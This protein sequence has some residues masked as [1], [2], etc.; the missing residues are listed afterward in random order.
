MKVAGARYQSIYLLYG[1]MLLRKNKFGARGKKIFL[2][3]G[4][5]IVTVS[6]NTAQG[7]KSIYRFFGY[8]NR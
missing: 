7:L 6:S 3:I 4:R 8:E 5:F 1:C 2:L